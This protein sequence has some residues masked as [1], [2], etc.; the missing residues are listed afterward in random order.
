M[1]VKEL[2][3]ILA[4]LPDDLPVVV[5]GES[6]EWWFSCENIQTALVEWVMCYPYSSQS[7][8]YQVLDLSFS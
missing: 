1:T 6:G 8:R 4:E 5:S 2:K 7:E 3:E